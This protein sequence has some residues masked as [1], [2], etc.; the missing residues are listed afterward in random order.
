MR[1]V[2]T[3]VSVC[4]LLFG[5]AAVSPAKEVVRLTNGEWPPFTSKNLKQYGVYSH[6]V[7]E[8]FTVEGVTVEYGFFPWKRSYM[9]VKHGGWDG[10]VTWA[11]TPEKEQEVFFSNP[12]FLH[13]K[14]FFHLISS[15]FD[16]NTIDDL[17]GLRI[18]ATAE[19]TYGDEFDQGAKNGTLRVEYVTADIQNLRKLLA[20]RIQIFPSDIDVGY[21]LLNTN[22]SPEDIAL[23]THHAKPIQETGTCVIFTKVTPKKSQRLQELFNRGLKKLK[24]N[25]R[26]EQM[27]EAFR[28]GAYQQK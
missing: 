1:W 28:R 15:T 6:I 24:A 2:F 4:V 26:Y 14:V 8:A 7:S 19:Y 20:Q 25:G 17:H 11:R 13:T 9:Y 21:F 22:F 27:L 3:P 16:W 18:G 10:S 5:L 23:I 12:V